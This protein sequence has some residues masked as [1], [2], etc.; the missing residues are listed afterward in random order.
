M[1]VC[2]KFPIT[3][4]FRLFNAYSIIFRLCH[5][6]RTNGQDVD[7]DRPRS[8]LLQSASDGTEFDLMS[9]GENGDASISS[10]PFQVLSIS[11]L[12][13]FHIWY[14]SFTALSNRI[15]C[16]LGL[17]CICANITL[18]ADEPCN[19]LFDLQCS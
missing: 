18:S 2:F 5:C 6:Y 4:R 12:L 15:S 14:V 19:S 16:F 7:D 8:R 1:C 11:S 3:V 10:I 17:P 9:S 13:L